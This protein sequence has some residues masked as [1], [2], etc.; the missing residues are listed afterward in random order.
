MIQQRGLTAKIFV[1]T[2]TLITFVISVSFGILYLILPDFYLREKNIRLEKNSTILANELSTAN[3]IE[4]YA[5]LIRDFSSGNNAFVTPFNDHNQLIIELSSPFL[6]MD[7]T[8]DS[9]GKSMA[10][11]FLE[12]K[13]L[14]DNDSDE[15]IVVS[16]G[17]QMGSRVGTTP[18]PSPD[19]EAGT[20][21]YFFFQ[22]TPD[23]GLAVD[24]FNHISIGVS[25]VNEKE[26]L[27]IRSSNEATLMTKPVKSGLIREIA[28]SSTLQPIDEAKGVLVALIPYLLILDF[29]IA[30]IATS[31]FAK[32]LTK[33]ILRISDA[34]VAMRDL[35]PEVLS[36]VRSNDELGILS[37]NIDSM[38]LNLRENIE[39]LKT[40][41]SKVAALEQSKTEFMR[42]AG[43]ELKTPISALNGIVE[44]MIDNVGRYQNREKYLNECKN[45]IGKLASLVNE[46]LVSSQADSVDETTGNEEFEVSA[47]LDEAADMFGILI[48]EKKLILI[49]EYT[50]ALIDTDR[51]LFR[52]A[53]VNLLSNAVQ[54]SPRNGTITL[55]LESTNIPHVADRSDNTGVYEDKGTDT[56]A[57]TNTVVLLSVENQCE[58]IPETQLQR[59]TEPFYTPDY[60]RSKAES[61]TGLG[62]YIVKK[63]L[64]RLGIPLT[65]TNTSSGLKVSIQLRGSL[66]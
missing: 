4:S 42:A 65:I 18:L 9:P 16:Q 66:N 60:S 49:R 6:M 23:E 56:A 26:A 43:H 20:G 11:R 57:D 5:T 34:T 40:E 24:R 3:D 58:P 62:L 46:I 19:K 35:K 28:V 33:P 48:E 29:L 63:N 45:Q 59:L 32:M 30:F 50:D 51:Q 52:Q 14:T 44:G 27:Y 61:G 13:E 25:G 47:L 37:R 41:M 12:Y 1:S 31:I 53:L 64:D 36:N 22:A 8:E 21:K 54:Y 39:N 10:I 38:Y 2:F 55:R 17:M 7:D 15:D